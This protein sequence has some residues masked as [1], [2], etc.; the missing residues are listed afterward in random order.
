MVN[1]FHQSNLLAQ[2]GAC[3]TNQLCTRTRRKSLEWFLT[4]QPSTAEALLSKITYPRNFYMDDCLLAAP[5]VD[6]D[7][8]LIEQVSTLLQHKEIFVL[9]GGSWMT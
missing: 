3:L 7:E 6:E 8:R 2:F 5:S 1:L 9:K 4:V